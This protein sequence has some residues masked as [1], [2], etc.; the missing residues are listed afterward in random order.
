MSSEM[1]K[2]TERVLFSREQLAA[3]VAAVGKQI[4]DDYAGKRPLLIGILKGSVIFMA[5]LMREIKL[6]CDIDF[7]I[8]KSY[9]SGVVSSGTVNIVKDA[10]TDITGRDIILIEDILDSGRTLSHVREYL[11]QRNPASVKI[12]ALLD[13]V[14]AEKFSDIKA[15]Y[16]CFDIENEFVVGY[17]LDYAETYRN[18]DYVGVL[19]RS[20]YE[21]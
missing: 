4:T 2:D 10:D 19:K 20:V 3:A 8:A 5:D 15:D 12:C 9:G 11:G 7:M 6:E 17:G 14:T 1:H 13:K 18:L 21:K 16:K